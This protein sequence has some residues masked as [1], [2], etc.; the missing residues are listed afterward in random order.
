MKLENVSKDFRLAKWWHMIS[1]K[2]IHDYS[3]FF[4]INNMYVCILLCQGGVAACGI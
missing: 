1:A 2:Q 3:A 4:V